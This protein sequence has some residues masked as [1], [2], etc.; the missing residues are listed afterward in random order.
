MV[1]GFESGAFLLRSEGQTLGES[2]GMERSG[3]LQTQVVMEVARR[4]LLDHEQP[5]TPG[6]GAHGLAEGLRCYI[7]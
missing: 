4:V 7:W 3:D 5:W 1:L 6:R 2:P